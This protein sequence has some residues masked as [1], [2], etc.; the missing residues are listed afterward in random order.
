MV[1]LL[2]NARE[3]MLDQARFAGA[4]RGRMEENVGALAARSVGATQTSH[5]NRSHVA[6]GSWLLFSTKALT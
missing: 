5:G 2:C 6:A 1:G 4:H 3:H